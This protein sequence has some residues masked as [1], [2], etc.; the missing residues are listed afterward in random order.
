MRVAIYGGTGFVGSYL[1]DALVAAGHDPAVLVRPGSEGKVRQRAKCRL[2]PGDIGDPKAVGEVLTGCDAAIYN[3]GIL[4]EK[5]SA[6]ITFKALQYEGAKLSIEAAMDRGI[7]RF[8][9]M[10]ANGVRAHG[11]PYQETKY[12]AERFLAQSE[13]DYTIFRP[14][15]VFGDPRG[16]M[17]FCTQLRDDMIRPPIPAPNFFTGSSPATGG[18]SMSPV[19]VRDVAE[20]FV[21]TLSERS[22]VGETYALCGP[23][24][25][26]WPEIVRRIAAAVGRKKTI[27]P[28][29][30][31]MVGLAASMLDRFESFPITRDQLDMLVEGNTGDSS[32]IFET[33]G[34]LPARFDVE[35]LAYLK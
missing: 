32:A 4:R 28:V 22:T 3:I 6:G 27:I 2:V 9:L 19:H 33:L 10:S 14:S 16:L 17:E 12:L 24:T 18:F 7:R 11:T 1:L 30:V 5:P 25:L 34:I 20:S 35:N 23:E 29:P 8:V 21:R 26:T 31:S 13:L 15:V